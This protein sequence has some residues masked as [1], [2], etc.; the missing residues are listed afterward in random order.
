MG[1]WLMAFMT[2]AK[3]NNRFI[4][5]AVVAVMWWA[6]LPA[7]SPT[8]TGASPPYF[9]LEA[10]ARHLIERVVA[11]EARGEP[12]EGM[13]AVAQVVL[14][15]LL[16]PSFPNAVEGVLREFA[17]PYN[18][19][20]SDDVKNAVSAVFDKGERVVKSALLFFMN[21]LK[22]SENGRRWILNNCT[23]VL[24][25]GAHVFYN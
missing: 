4:A 17:P 13:K 9:Y 15:R 1:R 25:I 20:I 22:A 12:F 18:G 19:H 3:R 10:Q 8:V 16:H 21:P 23:Q 2:A 14:D 24:T 5:L 11:A 6:V 7:H